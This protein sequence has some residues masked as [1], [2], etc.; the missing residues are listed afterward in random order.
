MS[1]T[2]AEFCLPSTFAP[3]KKLFKYT[4][5]NVSKIQ[6]FSQVE[7]Y[8]CSDQYRT[9]TQFTVYDELSCRRYFVVSI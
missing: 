2:L 5:I 6:L 8:A 7:Q 4:D 1:I 3:R 9:Y